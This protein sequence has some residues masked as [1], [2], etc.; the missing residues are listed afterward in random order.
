MSSALHNREKIEAVMHSNA[1]AKIMQMP[2]VQMTIAAY[3]SQL[4]TPDSRASQ[5]DA[6]MKNPEVQKILGLLAD[7]G[8][9]EV[10]LYGDKNFVDFIQLF[11]AVNAAQSY[12]PLMAQIT[13]QIH[14]QSPQ[15]IQAAAVISALVNNL[16]LIGVPN[17][18]VGFKVKDVDLA[19]EELI[20]LGVYA[21]IV[22]DQIEPL[23][24]RIQKTKVGKYDFL[25]LNLDGGMIPWDEVPLDKFKDAEAADGDVQKIVDH[26]KQSKLV[27][28]LGVRDN[29]LLVSIGRSLE[30]LEKLG[31][32]QRLIDRAEFKPLE[33]YA[34]RRLLGVGYVSEAF[35]RQLNSQKKDIDAVLDVADKCLKSSD[36]IDEQKQR[37]HKDIQELAKDVERMTPEAGAAMGFSFFADGG[38][39]GYQ[40]VWG[41]HNRLD[42]SKPLDLL[43]HVGGDPILGAVVRTK[44]PNVENYDVAVKWAKKAYGYFREF[45]LPAMKEHDR[46]RIE[47]FLETALPLA[48]RLDKANRELLIPALADGQLALVVDDKLTGRRF[49]V[50]L[51]EMEKPAAMIEPAIVLG[52]SDAKLFKKGLSEYRAVANGLIDAVRRIEGANVP[53]DFQIP[54]PKTVED[55]SRTLYVFT[56]P[57]AWGIHEKIEPSIAVSEKA[58]VFAVSRDHAD[59]LLKAAPPTIGGV[60]S[61]SERPLAGAVWIHWAAMLDAASPW[62]DLASEQIM[63]ANNVDEA[64]RKPIAEQVHTAVDVLKTLRTVSSECSIENGV[65]VTHTFAELRDVEK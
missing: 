35:S 12:G 4:D 33:K 19:K 63:T 49:V 22:S 13:G 47:K 57:G 31:K 58:A 23:K 1:W 61:Q 56:P 24:G 11:R 5:I 43:Q 14:D 51:P 44:A 65:L 6:A 16:K 64:Q 50:G 48:E 29:Y 40:Y 36:L 10:F 17:L 39:E 15:E 32:D 53:E 18:V 52:I 60:L 26:V 55:S 3:K 62:I 45:G 2:V 21:K 25:V 8:S 54:E 37:I 20:Q 59:R 30:C 9:D 41:N 7:M 34:D 42:G 38:I 46:E 27:I 28:A